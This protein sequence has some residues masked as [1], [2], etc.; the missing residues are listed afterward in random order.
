MLCR[1]ITDDLLE[2]NSRP[3]PLFWW[4][5]TREK[6]AE[7]FSQWCQSCH[8]SHGMD[9]SLSS[10]TAIPPVP[11][12]LALWPLAPMECSLHLQFCT[13]LASTGL[14]LIVTCCVPLWFFAL[15]AL[16]RTLSCG[17]S[18]DTSLI[19]RSVRKAASRQK[20]KVKLHFFMGFWVSYLS[21]C[22]GSQ[23]HFQASYF[24]RFTFRGHRSVVGTT[25]ISAGH[26]LMIKKKEILLKQFNC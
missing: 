25:E 14:D 6:A 4:H 9:S 24:Q 23:L 15:P 11:P 8:H 16:L 3:K 12:L 18:W 2:M 7:P 26:R 19:W 10:S 22:T 5:S 21:V 1:P 17:F 20:N 13:G